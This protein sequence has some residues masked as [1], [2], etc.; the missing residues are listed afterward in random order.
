MIG[1][2]YWTCTAINADGRILVAAVENGRLYISINGGENWSN[3]NNL[4]PQHWRSIAIS[5]VG[6]M[7][8][9]VAE[10]GNVFISRNY[11]KSWDTHRNAGVRHWISGTSIAYTCY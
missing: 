2:Q 8:V 3:R 7:I 11:G 6:D 10:R 4:T 1:E 5:S 9:A